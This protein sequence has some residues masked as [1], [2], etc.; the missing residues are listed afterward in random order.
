MPEEREVMEGMIAGQ[1]NKMI[2]NQLEISLRTVESRRHN[3][4]EKL[5][6]KSLAELVRLVVEIQRADQ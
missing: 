1:L 3:V 2:A 4:I 5:Q 6:V